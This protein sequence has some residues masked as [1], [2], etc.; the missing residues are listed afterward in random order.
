MKYL[1]A[2]VSVLFVLNGAVY[3]Y[4]PACTT[5]CITHV[6]DTATFN[7]RFQ[8]A[9]ASPLAI[10]ASPVQTVTPVTIVKG[11]DLAAQVLEWL[12][13]AFGSTAGG[14]FLWVV[15][16]GLKY[17]GIQITEAQKSQLQA[18]IVNGLNAA[19]ARAEANLRANPNLDI[20]IK[21]QIVADAVSYTQDH[22]AETIKALGLDP[23]SGEAI[24]AI[25]AR[26]ETALNDPK[27]PTP[28]V[29]TPAVAGGQA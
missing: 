28:A 2:L 29:V 8:A 14:A 10:G 18:I 13:V 4:A 23:K 20:P 24:D 3:A 15:V 5:D 25:K 17:L 1:L 6:S 9:Q 11:G 16:R 27:T 7:E 22:G 12:Q 19:A 26:I 21:S